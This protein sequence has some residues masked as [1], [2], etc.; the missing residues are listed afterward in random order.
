MKAWVMSKAKAQVVQSLLK[1]ETILS[2]TTLLRSAVNWEDWNHTENQKEKP[3]FLRWITSLLFISFSKS[4]IITERRLT[5]LLFLDIDFSPKRSWIQGPQTRPSNSLEN[6]IPPDT[7]WRVQLEYMK[8]QAHT[9]SQPPPG[10]QSGL[11]TLRK[12]KLIMT[13]QD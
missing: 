11:G 8:V 13:F 6:K 2:D 1:I 9:S 5:G 7:Y 4:L 3:H 10:I 12:P